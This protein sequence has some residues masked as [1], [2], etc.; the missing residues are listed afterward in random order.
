MGKTIELFYVHMYLVLYIRVYIYI[1]LFQCIEVEH[2]EREY[3][4]LPYLEKYMKL[5][6]AKVIYS[7][8]SM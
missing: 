8:S 4:E 1:Q 3:D 5:K 6:G 2:N 7:I